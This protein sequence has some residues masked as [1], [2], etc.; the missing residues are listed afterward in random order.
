MVDATRNAASL[1]FG[2]PRY[3]Y[4]ATNKMT[5]LVLATQPPTSSVSDQH[6]YVYDHVAPV[7]YMRLLAST[8][9]RTPISSPPQSLRGGCCNHCFGT[10]NRRFSISIPKRVARALKLPC[11]SCAVISLF[12]EFCLHTAVYMIRDARTTLTW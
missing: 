12:L 7:P 2:T 8:V 5:T 1:G 3:Q 11:R 4:E 6:Q 9:A 10:G